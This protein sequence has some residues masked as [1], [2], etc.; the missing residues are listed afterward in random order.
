MN[1]P[2]DL[3][4]CETHEW[5]RMEGETAVIGIT[6]FAQDQLGDVTFVELPAVGATLIEGSEMGSV[7]S[8]KAASDLFAPVSGKV[9]EVNPALE[10]SPELLNSDPYGQGWM[11]KVQLTAKPATLITAEEYQKLL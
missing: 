10:S 5:V 6:D 3:K 9:L 4:Y 2:A 1:I 11:L 8:V 7:E